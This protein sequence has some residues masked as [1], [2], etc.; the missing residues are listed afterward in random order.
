MAQ[1]D[2]FLTVMVSNNADSILLVEGDVATLLKDGVA[3]PITRQQLTP[4]QLLLLLREIAP[5]AAA[6]ELVGGTPASFE[7]A[8]ADGAFSVR[9]ARPGGRWH[10]SI[11]VA[12]ANGAANGAPNGAGNGHASGAPAPSTAN[13]ASPAAPPKGRRTSGRAKRA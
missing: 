5:E 3:R 6:A 9:T 2:R 10:A 7:Y 4:Q 12:G 8:T 11:T 13:G 1:L